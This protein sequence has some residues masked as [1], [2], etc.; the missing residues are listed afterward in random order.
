MS[1]NWI[2]NCDCHEPGSSII[3]FDACCCGTCEWCGQYVTNMVKHLLNCVSAPLD[4]REAKDRRK[5][6]H[7]V[8]KEG[9]QL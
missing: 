2:C 9:R 5:G 1:D 7:K 4:D 3:H 8:R 6:R